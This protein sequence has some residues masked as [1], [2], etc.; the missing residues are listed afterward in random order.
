MSE[1]GTSPIDFTHALERHLAKYPDSK[2]KL[3]IEKA[4]AKSAMDTNDHARIILYGE[5]V[6]KAEPR[7]DDFQLIDRVTRV[8]SG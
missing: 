6:L 7:R 2:Q 1:A 8:A 5:Q 4:L 3:A